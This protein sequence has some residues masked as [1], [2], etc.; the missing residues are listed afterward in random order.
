MASN[1]SNEDSP[2]LLFRI[3][4][5]NLVMDVIEI[6]LDYEIENNR[7]IWVTVIDEH[8]SHSRQLK[9]TNLVLIVEYVVR[10]SA[11]DRRSRPV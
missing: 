9:N 11:L 4:R 7:S 6:Y 2:E 3:D 8:V 1:F 5:R 10:Q